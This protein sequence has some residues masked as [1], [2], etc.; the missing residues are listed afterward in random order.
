VKTFSDRL[1]EVITALEETET[2]LAA[3]ATIK[4][5]ALSAAA[6]LRLMADELTSLAHEVYSYA[7]AKTEGL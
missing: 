7:T 1:R 5:L 4:P 6:Q 3:G 2:T